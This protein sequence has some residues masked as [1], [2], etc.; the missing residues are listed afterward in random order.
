MEDVSDSVDLTL[1]LRSPDPE[2]P[3]RFP[4]PLPQIQR[5]PK[6]AP[7]ECSWSTTI[8]TTGLRSSRPSEKLGIPRRWRRL[9]RS[10]FSNF[11]A[12]DPRS[13]RSREDEAHE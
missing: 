10:H 11:A 3:G 2:P 8:I 13:G 4:V 5:R 6:T 12:S 9:R 7:S 1:A